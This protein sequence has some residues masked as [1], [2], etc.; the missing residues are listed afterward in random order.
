MKRQFYVT[1]LFLSI[2][3]LCVLLPV[4][5]ATA[6]DDGFVTSI[7]EDGECG[8]DNVGKLQYLYNPDQDS[9]YEVTLKAKVTREGEIKESLDTRMVDAGDKKLLGCSFSDYQPLTTYQWSI[10]SETRK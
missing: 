7:T 6:D 8:H 10:I 5:A 1:G 3:A 9:G 4:S 2:L